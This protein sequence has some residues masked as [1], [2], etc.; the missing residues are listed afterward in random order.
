M[1]VGNRGS[2]RGFG[3]KRNIADYNAGIS[4][5]GTWEVDL[6]NPAGGYPIALETP[7]VAQMVWGGDR[8]PH[9]LHIHYDGAGAGALKGIVYPL[10]NADG[11]FTV[12][13]EAEV[14]IYAT[15]FTLVGLCLI[16]SLAA[17]NTLLV[18]FQGFHGS[19]GAPPWGFEYGA[20]FT[21]TTV[22]SANGAGRGSR[23]WGGI[24]RV[25]NAYTSG[26][27]ESG[28]GWAYRGGVTQATI[29][30]TPRFFGP[31]WYDNVAT[32]KD[33]FIHRLRQRH[34]QYSN[35]VGVN[36]FGA[37]DS[38]GMGSAVEVVNDDSK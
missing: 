9:G 10:H 34:F 8:C 14:A 18:W 21:T 33:I 36:T 16:D 7:A 12:E 15:N 24:T 25:G 28:R 22:A 37:L 30:F 6:S 23:S 29:G 11:D 35:T 2:W 13:C 27:S 5:Q 19:Y 1:T 4:S 38:Q 20:G 32:P 17:T 3:E 26:I 31:C